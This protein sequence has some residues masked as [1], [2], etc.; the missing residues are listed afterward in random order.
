MLSSEFDKARHA[1]HDI[2]ER[3]RLKMSILRGNGVRVSLKTFSAT[4]DRTSMILGKERSAL[5]VSAGEIGSEDE[6][7][8]H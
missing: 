7:V 1:E 3:K 6:Y 4:V 8:S 5:S 2:V